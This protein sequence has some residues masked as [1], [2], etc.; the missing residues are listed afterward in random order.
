[1]GPEAHGDAGAETTGAAGTLLGGGA[2]GFLHGERVDAATGVVVGDAGRAAVDD[3]FDTFDGEG[4]FGDV[5]ADD[6]FGLLTGCDGG[7][8]VLRREFA[9]QWHDAA[10]SGKGAPLN[11]GDGFADFVAAGHEDEHVAAEARREGEFFAG[12][13]GLV[14]HGL[15]VAVFLRHG[16]LI[17]NLDREG[18]A[19]GLQQFAGLHEID[20]RTRH[21]RGGH[22]ND[23]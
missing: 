18:A 1:M 21:E 19:L 10:T 7:V 3:G 12:A 4:G 11:G 15:G 9:M 5:G 17:A 20:E 6:D 13:G 22:D 8:L 14:P 23:L 2:A 16:G